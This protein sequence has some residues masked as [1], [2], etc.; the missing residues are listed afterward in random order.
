MRLQRI[1]AVNV[2]RGSDYLAFHTKINRLTR[3]QRISAANVRHIHAFHAFHVEMLMIEVIVIVHSTY[4]L[5]VIDRSLPP[6]MLDLNIRHALLPRL[7][8]LPRFCES[9]RKSS[10]VIAHHCASLPGRCPVMLLRVYG[11]VVGAMCQLWRG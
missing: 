4:C 9:P 5:L 8:R 11:W 6:K 1:S 7:P 2:R 3:L 10:R